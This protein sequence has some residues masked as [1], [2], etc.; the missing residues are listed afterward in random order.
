MATTQ[1]A[2]IEAVA[3]LYGVSPQTLIGVYG[4]ESNYGKNTGPSSA[5][6]EGP[7]QFLPSTGAEYGLSSSTITQ[8]G[9]SL[10]AAARYLKSLGANSDPQS[11]Q[12]ISA[13]NAYNGNGGGSSLTSYAN[14]VISNGLA[15]ATSGGASFGLLQSSPTLTGAANPITDLKSLAN[16]IASIPDAIAWFFKNW[17][18][19]LEFI[20]GAVLGVFGLV[21]LVRAG[22]Q[23]A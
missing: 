8:F 10:T 2:Q 17:L 22:K 18:R 3:K 1:L 7:F 15:A 5:G 4:T 23:A 12:T 19:I 16:T 21:L 11:A 9:P 20:G 14:S 13:L 6:A